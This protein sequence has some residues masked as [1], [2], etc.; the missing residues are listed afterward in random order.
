[1]PN[2][3]L[4]VTARPKVLIADPSMDVRSPLVEHLEEIGYRTV[5]AWSAGAASDLIAAD[6]IAY[7]ILE[8]RL[9]DADG[10]GL[11]EELLRSNPSARI[12]VHSAFCSVAVAV[13]AIKSGAVDV[14]PKPAEP[15][16]VVSLLL[17]ADLTRDSGAQ[18]LAN[19]ETL[20]EQHIQDVHAACDGN[21]MRA[22]R[23]LRMD[24]RTLQRLLAR[25]VAKR[26]AIQTVL[27]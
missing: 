19:P 25:T 3:L 11:I 16:F 6:D 20:R 4:P 18:H 12:M 8:L 17:G 5:I 13:R 14:L 15:T 7:A 9:E 21:T 24:R 22:A 23:E 10:F 26:S 1:M 2:D 27:R